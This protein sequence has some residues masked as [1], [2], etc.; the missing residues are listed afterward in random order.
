M[1]RSPLIGPNGCAATLKCV[2]AFTLAEML[3]TI[4]VFS[5]LV[6]A[7]LSLQLFG[8]NT[9]TIAQTKLAATDNGQKVLNHV[10]DEIRSGKLLFVGNG[11]A[12]SFSPLGADA[13]RTGNALMICPTANTNTFTY[14]YLDTN[15]Y[16]L[17]RMTSG[18]PGVEVISTC[19]TNALVFQ[20]EDFQGNVVTN[21]LNNRV[22]RLT[23]QFYRWE[24]PL[25]Q[26]GSGC[27]CDCF[28]VQSRM[29]R[30]LIE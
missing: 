18:N 20:A 9:Y 23:L 1:K 25:T 19:I 30:R 13:P 15:S 8:S 21:D 3:I 17:N 14:Y 24:Y 16:C 12:S 6:A 28:Q 26:L 29:A 5:L 10:R 27:M 11:N 22:I 2:A 4:A 7:S